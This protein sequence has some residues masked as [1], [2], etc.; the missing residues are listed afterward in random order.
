[1]GGRIVPW[2]LVLAALGAAAFHAPLRT[3]IEGRIANNI[4]VL[5]AKGIGV[6]PNPAVAARWYERAAERGSAAGQFNLGFALQ[7]GVGVAID[8]P[9]AE[10]WY[11]RAAEQGV[12]EAANN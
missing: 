5:Y 6:G 7:K 3:Y 1:M 10:R 11:R 8:E 9:A 12:T 4:G 2:I